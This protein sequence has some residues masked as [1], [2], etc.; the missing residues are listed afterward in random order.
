MSP[1]DSHARIVAE[2]VVIREYW[3][4]RGG[5]LPLK[6]PGSYYYTEGMRLEALNAASGP[7]AV[8]SYEQPKPGAKPPEGVVLVEPGSGSKRVAVLC[9]GPSIK[10]TWPPVIPAEPGA[11]LMSS[12]PLYDLTIAVNNAIAHHPADWWCCQ[13]GGPLKKYHGQPRVGICTSRS[14]ANSIRAGEFHPNVD[15]MD[16]LVVLE[17]GVINHHDVPR[18]AGWS[19]T[20]AIMLACRLGAKSID[21]YGV[22]HDGDEY[23]DGPMN[24]RGLDNRWAREARDLEAVTAHCEA[25]G[26]TVTRI[27]PQPQDGEE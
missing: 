13:D 23:F 15:S 18:V 16:G 17:S 7:K 11:A 22:D 2:N 14:Q 4:S 27:R 6:T 9:P 24:K 20:N 19:M 25:V 1:A 26:V 21:L 12:P 5:P 8:S 3:H 10:V